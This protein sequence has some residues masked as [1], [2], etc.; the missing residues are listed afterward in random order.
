[1]VIRRYIRRI[2]QDQP[3]LKRHRCYK[4]LAI[5]CLPQD[6]NGREYETNHSHSFLTLRG[7]FLTDNGF[8]P[9]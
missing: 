5:D 8:F 6:T 3:R 4:T 2:G 7:I 9:Q 1:M